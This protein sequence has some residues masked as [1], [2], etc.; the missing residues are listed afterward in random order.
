MTQKKRLGLSG[1]FAVAF[2]GSIALF[3]ILTF[4]KLLYDGRLSWP[5]EATFQGMLFMTL[6]FVFFG[7]FLLALGI[8]IMLDDN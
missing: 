2:G 4:A 3:P 7:L 1:P 8:E 5:Y 6:M